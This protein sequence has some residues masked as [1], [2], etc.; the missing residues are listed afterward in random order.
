MYVC[1][2]DIS[3]D[4]ASLS[5]VAGNFQDREMRKEMDRLTAFLPSDPS[6]I[7]HSNSISNDSEAEATVLREQVMQLGKLS[8]DEE[9]LMTCCRYC[10]PFSRIIKK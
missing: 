9:M 2:G 5:C 6:V 1:V 8:L 4:N 3:Q 7:I 10:S